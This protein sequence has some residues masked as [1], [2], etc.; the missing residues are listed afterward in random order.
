MLLFYLCSQHYLDEQEQP[1][2]KYILLRL[3]EVK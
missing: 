2:N 1:V 3:K